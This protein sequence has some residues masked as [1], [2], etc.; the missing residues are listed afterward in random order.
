M[1]RG[2]DE[3]PFKVF[4]RFKQNV[5]STI[6]GGFN[7][8]LGIPTAPAETHPSSSSTSTNYSTSI[9]S[10]HHHNPSELAMDDPSQ[11]T[12]D[13]YVQD[14]RQPNWTLSTLAFTPY[15]PL[16]LRHLPQPKP[17]GLPPH[18]DSSIFTFEDAYEDLLVMSLGMPLL[19]IMD[20]Y[21]LKQDHLKVF[22][23]GE[24]PYNWIGRMRTLGFL[25]FK[26]QSVSSQYYGL[27]PWPNMPGML[28][29][30][31][32]FGRRGYGNESN[33]ASDWTTDLLSQIQEG[34]ARLGGRDVTKEQDDQLQ[35]QR[36]P[37]H[38]DDLFS[39]ID[40]AFASGRSSWDALIKSITENQSDGQETQLPAKPTESQDER[41]TVT[42][43]EY[44][45]RFG[46]LHTKVY[47]KKLDSEGNK[48]G[49]ATSYSIRPADKQSDESKADSEEQQEAD[50]SDPRKKKGW[51]WK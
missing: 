20:K 8:V 43:S 33:E 27:G 10:Q 17:N 30:P 3:S 28:E 19:G 23:R 26:P 47:T 50:D 34:L 7:A 29:P 12:D 15:S 14:V 18:L 40:S 2:D 38:F 31:T 11:D 13:I 44:V 9:P 4:I 21:K 35:S 1:R 39:A 48:I 42:R 32:D 37:R 49:T 45:D 41:E 51:F 6:S 24:P 16:A 25:N 22:P 36:E 5:D 46:Y